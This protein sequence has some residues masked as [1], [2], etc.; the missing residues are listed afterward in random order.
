[1][2]R[3]NYG[4]ADIDRIFLND[5]D[6][7]KIIKNIIW[8]ASATTPYSEESSPVPWIRAN[9]DVF[10]SIVRGMLSSEIVLNNT[11]IIGMVLLPVPIRHLSM[12]VDMNH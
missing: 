5:K 8:L 11:R 2:V 12:S 1:M 3:V 7:K 6:Y 10:P 9:Y 4:P